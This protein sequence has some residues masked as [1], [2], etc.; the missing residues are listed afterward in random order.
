MLPPLRSALCAATAALGAIAVSPP[1]CAVEKDAARSARLKLSNNM[2]EQIMSEWRTEARR[3]CDLDIKA[4]VLGGATLG[5]W[6]HDARAA[7]RIALRAAHPPHHPFPTP[8]SYWVCR[9]ETGLAVVYKCR[10]ENTAMNECVK[11]HTNDEAGLEAFRTGR[12]LEI[13]PPF[14]EARGEFLEKKVAYLRQKY[15]EQAVEQALQG[16]KQ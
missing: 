12:L 11:R 9:Q 4:C 3:A 14:L 8:C 1:R 15:G 10:A 5:G 2:E 16:A 7:A 6:R 13:A